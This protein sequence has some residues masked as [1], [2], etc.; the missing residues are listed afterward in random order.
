MSSRKSQ[1]SKEKS[2]S[3]SSREKTK[4]SEQLDKHV[5]DRIAAGEKVNPILKENPNASN[6]ILPKSG[7]KA[8]GHI[9]RMGEYR[10]SPGLQQVR[11]DN[12]EN[13]EKSEPSK[14][15]KKESLEKYKD[16]NLAKV[17]HVISKATKSEVSNS[18][19]KEVNVAEVIRKAA[20][21]GVNN[22][23]SVSSSKSSKSLKKS[24]NKQLA[25][26]KT[27]DEK[28]EAKKVDEQN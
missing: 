17:T 1:S 6:I 26:S 15:S 8:H 14:S 16:E 19:A 20:K 21:G 2:K 10:C 18:K 3:Q 28:Q 12:K 27:S 23:K 22:S 25:S 4:E 24:S 7:C 13:L 5:F 11:F 9:L